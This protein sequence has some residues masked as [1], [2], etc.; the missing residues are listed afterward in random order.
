MYR[1]INVSHFPCR[2]GGGRTLTLGEGADAAGQTHVWS[3][4]PRIAPPSTRE[5][6]GASQ[7]PGT[8]TPARTARE[9]LGAPSHG[10][11]ERQFMLST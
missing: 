8:A 4:V 9:S 5:M 6:R 3:A 7:P 1:P 2:A 11:L 10:R